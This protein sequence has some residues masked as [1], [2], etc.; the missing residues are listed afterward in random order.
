LNLLVQATSRPLEVNNPFKIKKKM[1]ENCWP[2]CKNRKQDKEF[3]VAIKTVNNLTGQF[4]RV[5][6]SVGT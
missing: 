3:T 4:A 2:S 1:I 5:I 6:V